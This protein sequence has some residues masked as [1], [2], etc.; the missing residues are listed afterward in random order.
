MET[1]ACTVCKEVKENGFFTRRKT[2]RLGKL[3]SVCTPCKVNYNKARREHNP[4][5]I[6]EIERRSKFKRQYGISLEQY[7]EMLEN[8]G[9]GCAICGTTKPSERTKYFAVDH[10]HST[11]KV[12]G[13]L[14]SKCNRGLGL[15]NDTPERLKAAA[16]YL[17][18]G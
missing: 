11:S 9:G 10:C 1:R 13:L 5:Q 15:F 6:A 4:E 17:I 12:R 8:Q 16:K 14:C 3:V 18:G 2:H 7:D